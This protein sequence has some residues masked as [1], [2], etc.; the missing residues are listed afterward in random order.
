MLRVIAAIAAAQ[1]VT[2]A[3]L[4][5]AGTRLS[6]IH[7]TSLLLVGGVGLD[8]ALFMAREQ[9]DMEERARTLR[10]LITCNGMT[11]L[12]F[13]LLATC[14]TPILHDIGATIA[15]GAALSLG[16]AFLLAAPPPP[17]AAA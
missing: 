6:P 1:A 4:T 10:T 17:G 13:G 12:T 11:L 16:F 8:Y 15:L 7:L 14:T 9:L 5:L 3:L 2:L